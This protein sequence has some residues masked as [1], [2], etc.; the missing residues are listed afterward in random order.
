MTPV[1]KSDLVPGLYYGTET[2]L[3]R[4]GEL[5]S[6]TLELLIKVSGEYPFLRISIWNHD[7]DV[8]HSDFRGK[9]DHITFFKI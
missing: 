9:F 4:L 6:F 1:S 2:P 3:E 5:H 8:L 7:N